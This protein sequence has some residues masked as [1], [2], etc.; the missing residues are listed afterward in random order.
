MSRP[1]FF[2][3]HDLNEHI[4]DGLLRREPTIEIVRAR[5]VGMDGRTDGEVLAYAAR[6]RLIVVSHDV[7]T[8]CAAAYARIERGEAMTGLMMVRQSEPIAP[9]IENLLL[10]WAGS[11]MEEWGGGVWF[12]PI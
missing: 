12:L 6:E 1:R 2:A 11:E 4:V 3:D 5:A 8:M 9:A 10:I 7:N